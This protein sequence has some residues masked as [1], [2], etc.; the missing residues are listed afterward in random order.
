MLF[1]SPGPVYV[2]LLD[3]RLA[4]RDQLQGL[5]FV[6]QRRFTRMVHGRK[7][8]PG[9]AGALMLVAGPELG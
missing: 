2:D 7:K 1:R 3:Q 4:L 5:R 8:A 6:Q 9:D